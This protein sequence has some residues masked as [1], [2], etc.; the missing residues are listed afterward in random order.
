MS[1]IAGGINN[2][3]QAKAE[4]GKVMRVT[5]IFWNRETPGNTVGIP[6]YVPVTDSIQEIKDR[7]ETELNGTTWTY[8]EK[9]KLRK[10]EL[11]LEEEVQ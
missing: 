8:G 7:W 9:R 2:E 10:L 4:H 3:L 1:K 5:Y 6:W 11:T